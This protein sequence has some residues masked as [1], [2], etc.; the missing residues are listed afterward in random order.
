MS[1]R[2]TITCEKYRCKFWVEGRCTKNEIELLDNCNAP[3]TG[4]NLMCDT[5][6]LRAEEPEEEKERVNHARTH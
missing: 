6:E 4:L 1:T 2:T 3:T 5:F